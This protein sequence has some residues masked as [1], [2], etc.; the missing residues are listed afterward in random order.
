[1]VCFVR[2]LVLFAKMTQ[3]SINYRHIMTISELGSQGKPT[4]ELSISEKLRRG[5]SGHLNLMSKLFLSRIKLHYLKSNSQCPLTMGNNMATLGYLHCISYKEAV[6]DKSINVTHFLGK[7]SK[8]MSGHPKTS[9]LTKLHTTGRPKG[10]NSQ[11]S[12]SRCST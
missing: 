2:R 11:W 4:V 8:R 7:E 1:M 12:Q 6:A 5:L 3:S 10:G 9:E